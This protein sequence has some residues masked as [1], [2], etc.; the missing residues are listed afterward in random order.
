M[1]TIGIDPHKNTHTALAL[2][3]HRH[4]LG[5]FEARNDARA[6]ARLRR[7]A[8][9]WPDRCWAIEGAYGLGQ[10]LAQDL[11]A[12]GEHVVEVPSK[13]SAQVRRLGEGGHK[14][15]RRDAVSIATAAMH[16]PRLRPVVAEGAITVVRVLLE[17]R[18]DLDNQR[19]RAINRLHALLRELTPGGAPTGLN[20][21]NA[22][23]RLKT[24]RPR[25]LAGRQRRATAVEIAG[26][27]RRLER[28]LAVNDTQLADAVAATRTRLTGIFGAGH[29][30]AAIILSHTDDVNRFRSQDAYAAYAGVAPLE[31]SSGDLTRHRVNTGGHRQLN[32]A[33]HIIAT[34]QIRHDTDGRRY[35]LRKRA[36]G[37]TPREAT[38]CLKRQIAKTVW[39]IL[40]EDTPAATA[41]A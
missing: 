30:V 6:A 17:R 15:D 14:S 4:V 35:W 34:V 18:S 20:A 38:R 13:L 1:I 25:D 32:H 26:D 16:A 21:T 31:A 5:A 8:A 12:E 40:N 19:T 9:Q 10:R 29:V 28:Q 33:L 24:I 3:E 2:D 27:I 37:K 23:A 11:L 36:E 7:W 41:A 22:A 39:R